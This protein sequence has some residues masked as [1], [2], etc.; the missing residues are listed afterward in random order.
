MCSFACV[1][2]VLWVCVCV[3]E[4]EMLKRNTN[5]VGTNAIKGVHTI[6]TVRIFGMNGAMVSSRRLRSG[7]C[8]GRVGGL[9]NGI[10]RHQTR[11]CGRNDKVGAMLVVLENKISVN[12]G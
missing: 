11:Y 7:R 12:C 9:G 2:V 8:G 5:I 1:L 3:E 4:R 6:L 10:R